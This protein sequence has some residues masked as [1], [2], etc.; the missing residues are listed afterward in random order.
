MSI[1][2]VKFPFG[3]TSKMLEVKHADVHMCSQQPRTEKT[4]EWTNKA[5]PSRATGYCLATERNGALTQATMWMDHEDMTL[6]KEARHKR[7]I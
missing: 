5:W 4:E 6:S 2:K 1:P 7:H 3:K